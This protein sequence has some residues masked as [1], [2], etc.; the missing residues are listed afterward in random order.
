[1][2]WDRAKKFSNG[3]VVL[4]NT[5]LT[6]DSTLHFANSASITIHPGGKLIIDGGTLTNA[7]EGEM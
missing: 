5:Q 3:I 6:I 7:C 1:M 4:P 2:V